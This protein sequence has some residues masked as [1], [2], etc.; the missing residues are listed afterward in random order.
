[1]PWQL[2]QEA[3]V[4]MW[5]VGLP[6]A[7]TPLWQVAQVPGW[8]PAWSNRAGRQASVEWQA[9][10]LLSAGTWFAVLP[11]AVVPLWQVEQVPCT[12]V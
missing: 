4:T 6:V 10:Q 8:T 9:S 1:M 12:C 2:S 7:R 3:L 11:V 5:F